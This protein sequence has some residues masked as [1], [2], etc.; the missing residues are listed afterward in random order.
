MGTFNYE[1]Q[2]GKKYLIY[3]KKPEEKIDPVTME[4]MSN[5]QIGSLLSFE[6]IQIDGALTLKYNVT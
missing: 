6:S 1:E 3:N 2:E 4:M 5:N